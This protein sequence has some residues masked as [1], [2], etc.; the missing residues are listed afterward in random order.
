MAEPTPGTKRTY[1]VPRWMV[2]IALPLLTIHA[3]NGLH[4]IVEWLS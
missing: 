3:I 2:W 1:A 4:L